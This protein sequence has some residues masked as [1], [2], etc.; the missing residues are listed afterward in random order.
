MFTCSIVAFAHSVY[1]WMSPPTP[2][3]VPQKYLTTTNPILWRFAPSSTVKI[4][5]HA[6]LLGSPSS[7][8][9]I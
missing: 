9:L 6:V 4:G 7:L 2:K 5:F 8:A 1:A 3:R